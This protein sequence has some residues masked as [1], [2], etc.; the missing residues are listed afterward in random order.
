MIITTMNDLP[1]YRIDEVLGEVFGLTVRSR[2]L[3]SQ[4]GAGFKSLV[5]GELKEADQGKAQDHRT[6]QRMR[7]VPRHDGVTEQGARGHGVLVAHGRRGDRRA[8]R[9]AG[10][11]TAPCCYQ[12]I[13]WWLRCRGA[14]VR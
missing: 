10:R 14:L 1:G 2:N 4:I 7:V 6:R 11:V 13:A 9:R 12:T 8:L 5:G 3:G